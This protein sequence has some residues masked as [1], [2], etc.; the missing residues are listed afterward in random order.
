MYRGMGGTIVQP[1]A[2]RR[3]RLD[4]Y[5]RRRLVAGDVLVEQSDGA[6]FVAPPCVLERTDMKPVP[7]LRAAEVAVLRA[8]EDFWKVVRTTM[9][10]SMIAR[11]ELLDQVEAWRAA[12]NEKEP[13]VGAAS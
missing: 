6:L 5:S 10:P 12:R 1:D 8:A 4:E 9:A 11:N 2:Q 7:T 13:P 3:V